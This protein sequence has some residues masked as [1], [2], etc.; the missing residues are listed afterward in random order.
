MQITEAMRG[1]T[2]G[3]DDTC[4]YGH[5]G[6]PRRR[7]VQSGVVDSDIIRILQ[8]TG[9]HQ[10]GPMT[11][12]ETDL[13]NDPAEPAPIQVSGPVRALRHAVGIARLDTTAMQRASRDRQALLYGAVIAG[14]AIVPQV[15]AGMVAST[16]GPETLTPSAALT[17]S[18]AAVIM[19]LVSS[20]IS[21]AIMHGAAKLLFGATGSYL[22]LLRVLW[23]G[24]IVQVIAVVP[25]IGSIVAG[26]WSL[27]I[28][29][30]AFEEVDGI[31]RLQAL[32][33]AVG[34]TAIAYAMALVLS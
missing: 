11:E 24:S 2:A 1:L 10:R 14:A 18:A 12:S 13:Q 30:I 3:R 19:R 5:E 26:I 6:A 4:L 33:L 8:T 22:G 17:F 31:E 16:L 20:A 7:E 27:L 15:V 28:T 34:F 21:T 32:V 29:L 23:L 9:I 25:V